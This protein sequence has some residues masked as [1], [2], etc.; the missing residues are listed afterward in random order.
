[1]RPTLRQLEYFVAV[2][3]HLA[4]GP[5]AEALA[6]TQPSLSKQIMT[7]EAELGV[8]LFERSS[9]RVRL[10]S[11]GSALLD[12]A[13]RVLERA[14]AFRDMARQFARDPVRRMKAG[15]LPSIGAYFMP[16]LLERLRSSLPELRISLVEGASQGLL[17]RLRAGELD[18]VVASRGDADGLER[19]H[20]FDE[21]LW[22]SSAPDDPLMES[23][24]PAPP[25]ALKGRALLTLGPEFHLTQL[26][27]GLAQLAG[28]TA[29][30]DYRGANL[31]AVR[32]MAASGS[33]IAVLP[34]LYALGEAV[35]DPNFKVR[36]IDHP[37]ALH[38]VFLY[39]RG[40]AQRADL[41]E[42][43][44]SEMMAEKLRIRSERAPKFQI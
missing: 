25:H 21:T 20:L 34:S 5:A 2:A 7:L 23:E 29:S 9:R 22:I 35:R 26:T 11:E 19:H 39:W 12:E 4:F 18:F 28:A 32:S 8:A 37:S 6:V 14:R 31:D 10:T 43:L 41:F 38:P 30:G 36:R 42:T 40:S 1:M 3:D 15:V 27:D 44:A 17:G 16:R 24:A 13:R 33:G